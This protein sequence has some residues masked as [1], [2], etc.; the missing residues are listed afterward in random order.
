MKIY[1]QNLTLYL[2][3]DVGRMG[4]KRSTSILWFLLSQLLFFQ[5]IFLFLHFL[6]RDIFKPVL[7]QQIL[8]K[9]S[10]NEILIFSAGIIVCLSITWAFL[11]NAAVTAFGSTKWT[12][13]CNEKPRP[14]FNHF[15]YH[16]SKDFKKNVRLDYY[17][18][19]LVMI[20]CII[21]IKSPQSFQVNVDT[22]VMNHYGY[23]LCRSYN[24]RLGNNLNLIF[25]KNGSV[26]T[27]K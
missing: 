8:I 14:Y 4:T 20:I 13:Y 27:E 17:L 9:I 15:I 12:K 7:N 10:S 21:F 16:F 11:F 2:K 26:C 25:V 19:I 1:W 22:K 5:P 23:Y 24:D 18:W 6:N 3:E